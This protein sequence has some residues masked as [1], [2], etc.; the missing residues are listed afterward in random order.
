MHS[1]LSIIIPT[2]NEEHYLPPLLN[3]L[4]GQGISGYEIIIADAR[5]RDR[6]IEIATRYGCRVVAGGKP[7][8]GR[9]E[10]AKVAQGDFLLFL[11]AD[12]VLPKDFLKRA[13]DEFQ[14]RGLDVVSFCLEPQT[15]NMATKLLF[16][17]FYNWPIQFCEP[18]LPHGAIAIL[19]KR[20]IHRKLE[21]FDEEITLAE[22]HDYVRR[23]RGVGK[24]GILR[25]ARVSTSLRRLETD[26]WLRTYLKYVLTEVHMIALGPVKSDVFKY[27]FSHYRDGGK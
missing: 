22:D 23:A 9:N 5:S 20:T 21:G 26:G 7:A 25:S 18:V 2:L 24:F 19:V 14:C 11:D 8:K 4:R 12:T 1:V 10:G 6:T 16:N 17:L 15:G 27:R 13:L 3:S